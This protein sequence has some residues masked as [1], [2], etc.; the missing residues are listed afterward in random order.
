M[1]I[2]VCGEAAGRPLEA[3]ALVG[4]GFRHLSMPASGVGRVKEMIRSLAFADA[5]EELE[6]LMALP[7]T[8][9]RAEIENF[10]VAHKI[11]V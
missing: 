5:A 4:L 7:R 10:A 1:P 8:S 9:V 6:R 3:L 11:P 2:S